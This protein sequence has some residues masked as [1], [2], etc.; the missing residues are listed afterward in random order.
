M[1]KNLIKIMSILLMGATLVTGCNKNE[2]VKNA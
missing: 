2:V 1:K